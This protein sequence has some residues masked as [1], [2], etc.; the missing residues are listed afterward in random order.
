VTTYSWPDLGS[1]TST[2]KR[3]VFWLRELPAQ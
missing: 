1:S 3:M 2:D